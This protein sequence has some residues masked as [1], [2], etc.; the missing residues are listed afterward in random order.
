MRR[1]YQGEEK[2]EEIGARQKGREEN[3]KWRARGNWSETNSLLRECGEQMAREP[4][5]RQKLR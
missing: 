3:G 4:R 1:G 5:V 2:S